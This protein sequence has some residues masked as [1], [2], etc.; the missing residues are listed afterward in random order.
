[1]YAHQVIEDCRKFIDRLEH[2]SKVDPKKRSLFGDYD[3]LIE[4]AMMD[5]IPHAQKFHFDDAFALSDMK[6][7]DYLF[8][9]NG[10]AL[11][12]PY[13]TM[14]MDFDATDT[15]GFTWKLGVLVHEYEGIFKNTQYEMFCFE[16]VRESKLWTMAPKSVFINDGRIEDYHSAYIFKNQRATERLDELIRI[17]ASLAHK[18]I[19]LL[20]CKNIQTEKIKAP[21]ALNRKRTKRGKQ[22]IFDYHVLNVV[23]P[24]KGRGYSQ[25]TDPLSHN[26]IHLCRGHFKEYTEEHPLFGKYTGLYWWQ[27]H[28]RGQNKDGIVVKDYDVSGKT[29]QEAEK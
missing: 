1:M 19:C 16:F 7:N 10:T 20:N 28:V 5:F 29:K 25:K 23:V 14:W 2:L 21:A 9:S 6:V 12:M 26:R 17:A 24:S 13:K 18:G 3:S 15:E 22:A 27:P 11:K 4:I 8:M